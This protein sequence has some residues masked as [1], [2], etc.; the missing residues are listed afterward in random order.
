[1]KGTDKQGNRSTMVMNSFFLIL[2]TFSFHKFKHQATNISILSVCPSFLLLNQ[3][4]EFHE[5]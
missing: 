5:M 3:L 2:E 1:M 4:T